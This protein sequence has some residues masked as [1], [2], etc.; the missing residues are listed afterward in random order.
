MSPS[1]LAACRDRGVGVFSTVFSLTI[2]L[3]FLLF[4]TQL[5][6]RLYQSSTLG[7]DAYRSARAVADG[8]VQRSGPAII[9]AVMAR[10]TARLQSRYGA[11]GAVVRWGDSATADVLLEVTIHPRNELLGGLDGVLGLRAIH[12]TARVHRETEP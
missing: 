3:G 9:T 12:R 2:F 11:D 10:E 1:P 5:S 8:S 4:A 6:L 7:A